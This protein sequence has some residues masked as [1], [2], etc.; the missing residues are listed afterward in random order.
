LRFYEASSGSIMIDET[1]LADLEVAAWR[2]QVG[3]VAQELILLHDSVLQ[4]ITLGDSRIDAAAVWQALD[5]AG[6]RHF[7]EALPDGVHTVVGSEGAK[8]SGGQRQ[9]IALTRA[10]ARRPQLLILDEATSALDSGTAEA[11]SR[12]IVQLKGK[13]TIIVITHR[14]EYRDVAD[15][16]IRIDAGRIVEQSSPMQTMS[17]ERPDTVPG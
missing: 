7:V 8:L 1:P 12:K 13:V 4:N 6:A 5:L 10:L 17:A 15:R 2:R 16:L 3:Y 11:I 9:R 14:G